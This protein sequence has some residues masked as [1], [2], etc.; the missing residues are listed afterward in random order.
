MITLTLLHWIGEWKGTECDKSGD[1]L[2]LQRRSLPLPCKIVRSLWPQHARFPCDQS[3]LA[4]GDF[5]SEKN[6]QNWF[7]PLKS[8]RHPSLR[9]KIANKWRCVI[10]VHSGS[11]ACPPVVVLGLVF[12]CGACC[13]CTLEFLCLTDPKRTW[14]SRAAKRGGA[15][16]RGGFPDLDLSFLFC[17][18]WD[19]PDVSGIFPICSG[20]VRGF[21]RFVLFLF[22]GL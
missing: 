5:L 9:W 12:S 17:P 13:T 16:N 20:M 22:L 8:L 18:F 10:L 19:F 14:N 11:E 3:S 21:S 6:W 1:S 15:S 7:P 2:R 4:N